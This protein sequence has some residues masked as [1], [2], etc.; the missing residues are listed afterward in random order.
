MASFKSHPHS[1]CTAACPPK[2][3]RHSPCR[4]WGSGHETL[5]FNITGQ[6][7]RC[8]LRWCKS[9]LWV[10]MRRRVKQGGPRSL[11]RSHSTT[12]PQGFGAWQPTCHS[13]SRSANETGTSPGTPLCRWPETRLLL[14]ARAASTP[15]QVRRQYRLEAFRGC[16]DEHG[17]N[18][19]RQ[20]YIPSSSETAQIVFRLEEM[21]RIKTQAIDLCLLRL[22]SSRS[23]AAPPQRR[24]PESHRRSW[25]WEPGWRGGGTGGSF[26]T[27][28]KGPKL[29]VSAGKQTRL[30]CPVHF[31]APKQLALS[32][33]S[34]ER[35][36]W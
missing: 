33:D 17:I 20:I 34:K 15:P 36:D 14:T 16:S 21:E 31:P 26:F 13:L 35:P 7:S 9:L 18:S 11:P 5:L 1:I 4:L 30:P 23:A 28:T 12:T 3:E 10:P 29:D 32:T 8:L 24:G 19:S 2:E 27:A 25:H 6:Q 22:I